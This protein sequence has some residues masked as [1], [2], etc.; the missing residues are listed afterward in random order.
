[1]SPDKEIDP[2][3]NAAAAEWFARL[4]DED[5]SEQD[6]VEWQRWLAAHP[7]HQRAHLGMEQ[8]WQLLGHAEKLPTARVAGA[9]SKSD[10]RRTRRRWFMVLA[11]AAAA[12]VIS[13][14]LIPILQASLNASRVRTS[15]AEQ[16]S[17]RLED[18]SRVTLGG[19]SEVQP[20]LDSHFRRVRLLRGE[21][22][23]EVARD[24]S[25]PFLVVAGASEVRAIGTAFNVHRE[26][27]G[28]VV[29]VA[30]GTVSIALGEAKPAAEAALVLT[31]GE[32][33]ESDGTR[34]R[35]LS[36]IHAGDVAS[37]RQGR[38]EYLGEPLRTVIEDVNRYSDQQIVLTDPALGALRYTG[39]VLLDHVDEWLTGI[40]GTLPVTVR[41]SGARYEI[42]AAGASDESH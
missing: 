26:R 2:Q 5:A 11:A 8:C 30:D 39:T 9:V 36:P 3:I 40:A 32:R 1:M 21:A 35:R 19:R 23:F 41:Q 20:V 27:T 6:F 13:L 38:L 31:A 34:L 14:L 22:F 25:R 33:A 17:I 7:D 12:V 37:W 4:M 42:S 28:V 24:P 18:G 29:A 16:R 15:T 10:Q